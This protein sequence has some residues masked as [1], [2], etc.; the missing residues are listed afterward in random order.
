MPEE[1]ERMKNKIASSLK[2]KTNPKTDKPYTESDIYAIATAQW[3]KGHGGKAP[4]HGKEEAKLFSSKFEIKEDEKNF[5]V[6]GYVATSHPDRAEMHD[7]ELELDY[8]GDII[9]KNTLQKIADSINSRWFPQAGAVSERHDWVHENNPDK[10]LAGVISSPAKLVQLDDGE[11]AVEAEVLVNKMNPRYE[12]VKY[13]VENGIYPGFSIEYET[14]DYSVIEK[15]GKLYRNLDDI[16][17][18]GFG[19]ASRRLIANPNA[20]ITEK[21]YKEVNEF[22]IKP[23]VKASENDDSQMAECSKCHKKM[24]KDMLKKHM[25]EVH[26]S[27]SKEI[28]VNKMENVNQTPETKMEGKENIVDEIKIKEMVNLEI[29]EKVKEAVMEAFKASQPILETKQSVIEIKETKDYRESLEKGNL[30]FKEANNLV[31]RFPIIFQ[32]TFAGNYDITSKRWETELKASPTFDASII[33][34]YNPSMAKIN[35]KQMEVKAALAA[36]NSPTNNETTYYQAPAELGDFYDP[37]IIS[38][39]NDATTLFGILPKEDYSERQNIQF[40]VVTA[41]PTA[42]GYLEGDSTWTSTNVTRLKL[43]QDYANYRV[44]IEVT[45]QMLQAA[46]GRG[47][48]GDVWGQEVERATIRLRKQI[49]TDILTGAAGTYNGTDARY[50]L[51]LQHLILTTGNLYGKARGTY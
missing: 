28:E 33:D 49:N 40:R 16:N 22:M 38:H 15:E 25:D 19:F 23:E 29:K 27:K 39:L 32:K 37:V 4:S 42:G 51:G 1:F 8:D 50:V 26:E 31:N 12:E 14:N 21:S 6:K 48:I 17:M 24:G 2:G 46:A 36:F 35:V 43:E 11:S 5:Y 9:P 13:N 47:G 18:E 44:I 30:S 7:N 45:G 20:I 10:P 34:T 41:D 3:K